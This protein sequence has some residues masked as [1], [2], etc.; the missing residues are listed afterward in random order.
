MTCLV[1]LL[2]ISSPCPFPAFLSSSP[3]FR[4]LTS[5]HYLNLS[6]P[7]SLSVR[8]VCVM[9]LLFLFLFLFLFLSASL[10]HPVSHLPSS[11][12]AF[13]PDCFLWFLLFPLSLAFCI[14][15]CLDAFRFLPAS[16]CLA[17]QPFLFLPEHKNVKNV[18][19]NNFY[20]EM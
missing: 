6:F 13:A 16:M 9:P 15:Y 18:L 5:P 12:P 7:V 4:L 8:Q 10:R 1:P 3:V 20:Q 19:K 14:L 17:F 11:S 2:F